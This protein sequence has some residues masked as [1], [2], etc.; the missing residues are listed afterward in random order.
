MASEPTRDEQVSHHEAGHATA[1]YLLDIEVL[2][3][4]IDPGLV[5]FVKPVSEEELAAI[6]KG[7]MPTGAL[8]RWERMLKVG[9]AGGAGQLGLLR[10]RDVPKESVS[11]ILR[12]PIEDDLRQVF[13]EGLH[14]HYGDRPVAKQHF[15]RLFVET[16]GLLWGPEGWP[17]VERLAMELMAKRTL[18]G[19][20]VRRVL[21][22][23]R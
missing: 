3:A 15:D 8:P 12:A 7:T 6:D 20:A 16:K 10:L 22:G 19:E 21:G 11:K 18:D 23:E 4:T 13:D 1:A 17:R 9:L 2:R 14:R 5:E